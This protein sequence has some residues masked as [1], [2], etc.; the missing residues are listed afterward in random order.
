LIL[1]L[2]KFFYRSNRRRSCEARRRSC[3][4]HRRY[5]GACLR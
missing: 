3:E 2:I 4:A 5:C 1:I